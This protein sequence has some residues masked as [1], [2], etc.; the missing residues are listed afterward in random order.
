MLEYTLGSVSR[1]REATPLDLLKNSDFHK[2]SQTFYNQ[3]SIQSKS[4]FGFS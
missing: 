4:L 3:K 1:E 2:D